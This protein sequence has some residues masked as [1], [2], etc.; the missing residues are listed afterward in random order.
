MSINILTILAACDSRVDNEIIDNE[1]PTETQQLV[2]DR[3]KNI[4]KIAVEEML[5]HLIKHISVTTINNASVNVNTRR[6]VKSNSGG[7]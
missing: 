7:K 2:G 5:N 1:W 3:T 4:I 6:D